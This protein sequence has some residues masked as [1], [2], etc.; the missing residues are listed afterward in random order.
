M[1]L[2]NLCV[3]HVLFTW[4]WWVGVSLT[5]FPWILWLVFRKRE[6]TMHFDPLIYTEL[7]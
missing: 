6:C 5:I 7:Q 3:E 1:T 2:Q 4:Q